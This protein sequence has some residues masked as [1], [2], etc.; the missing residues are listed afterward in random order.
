[1]NKVAFITGASGGIGGA[2][3]VA[4]AAA[5]YCV[6]AGYH[7]G[8]ARAQALCRAIEGDGGCAVPVPVD[9]RSEADV[10]Q[11]FDWTENRLGPVQVL[12]NNAGTAAQKLFGSITAR[13]W[14]D[15]FAVH[16]RGA[17][18]CSKRALG[19]M[20]RQKQGCILNVA[21]M[22]G[23]VGASCEVHYAAAKAAVIG[24]TKS[25]AKEVGP[26]GIRVNCIAPGAINTGMMDAFAP[27]D[28]A[29]LCEEIPLGR[30]GTPQE[31]AGL[32]L[33]L[34][35][36]AAGYITGQVLAP[37]GGFVV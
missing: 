23:Q 11:A 31:V 5:G 12:V 1:M 27:A 25:L 24:L 37:N 4:F 34:A 32:A 2:M 8:K 21:S 15:M 19:P 26:S 6:A 29:A 22:W 16:A 13:E 20:L 3:A 33:F 28:K 10:L 35:G 9:V 18:L 36:D 14:D 7:T 17:F 30:L